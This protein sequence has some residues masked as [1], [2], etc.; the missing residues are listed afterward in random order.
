MA[1]DETLTEVVASGASGP[2]LRVYR[3]HGR[4]LS[5]GISQSI[6]DVDQFACEQ[7]GVGVIRRSSG[8]TSVLHTHQIGWSLT[9]PSAHPLAPGDIIQ[10]Y[11]L[12][13][14]IALSICRLLGIEAVAADIETARLPISDPLLAIACFGSLAPFE[15]VARD[16]GKKL[17]GW[18]QVRRRGV[19]MHHGVMSL[20]FHPSELANLLKTDRSRLAELL[21]ARVTD[22][23]S[24][25]KSSIT[26]ASIAHA[27]VK[28][29]HAVSGEIC[30]GT[31]SEP[32]RR[33][34]RQIARERFLDTSWTA[35]R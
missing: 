8:G 24:L 3:W 28:A 19:V 5:I 27:I 16:S 12:Q 25:T 29:H 2:V 7:A 23:V 30:F 11:Q 35:R 10:S 14:E 26:F 6:G 1:V 32:E 21:S 13:S 34:S 17:I 31:L 22:V 20:R 4:W 33:R 9:L 18:G 15:I